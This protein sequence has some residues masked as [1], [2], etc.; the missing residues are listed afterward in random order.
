MQNMNTLCSTLANKNKNE[1]KVACD[2]L[3]GKIILTLS[4]ILDVHLDSHNFSDDLFVETL[5]SKY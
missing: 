2:L 4:H 1:K 5:E 3:V